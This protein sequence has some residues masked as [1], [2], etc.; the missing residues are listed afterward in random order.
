M[1]ASCGH[2]QLLIMMT[3]CTPI[4]LLAANLNRQ[5]QD[6]RRFK[7]TSFVVSNQIGGHAAPVKSRPNK[8]NKWRPDKLVRPT[9]GGRP[10]STTTTTTTTAAPTTQHPNVTRWWTE[11]QQICGT[12]ATTHGSARRGRII[13]GREVAY[14]AVPWQVDLRVFRHSSRHFEHMCG[15]SI[16]SRYLVLTAAHCVQVSG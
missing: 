7:P 4:V 1:H 6:V 16:I 2:A 10:V 5:P 12:L 8:W 13:G 3:F 15:G 9:V 11:Q 14:G